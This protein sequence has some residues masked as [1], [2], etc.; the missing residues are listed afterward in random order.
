MKPKLKK[1]IVCKSEFMPYRSTQK[2]CGMKCAIID[3]KSKEKKKAEEKKRLTEKMKWD[4]I[5]PNEYRKKYFQPVVNE[6]IR[7]IDKGQ[8]CICRPT[9]QGNDA[10]HF[11]STGANLTLSLNFHNIHLQSRNSNG[12]RGGESLKFYKGLERV[13]GK[14]Y[15]EFCDQLQQC[16]P[17]H[18]TKEEMKSARERLMKFRLRIR[19]EILKPLEAAK[20]IELRN[21]ANEIINIY[22][23][24]YSKYL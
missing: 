3:A 24:N 8:P 16:E 7:I 1:C 5:T 6:C 9:E 22:E 21:E 11:I 18:L 20:R 2:V 12:F 17:L 14:K 10:G 4:L 15:A 13:Y 23:K 19:K